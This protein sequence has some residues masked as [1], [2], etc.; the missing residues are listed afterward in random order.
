MNSPVPSVAALPLQS[1]RF[2]DFR[3]TSTGVQCE[4]QTDVESDML[5]QLIATF[6]EP[7]SLPFDGLIACFPFN[8][9]NYLFG[10]IIE[11]SGDADRLLRCH[12]VPNADLQQAISELIDSS[13]VPNVEPTVARLD[14]IEPVLRCATSGQRMILIGTSPSET[15]AAAWEMVPPSC[16]S[17]LTFSA[18]PFAPIGTCIYF[19]DRFDTSRLGHDGLSVIL[20]LSAPCKADLSAFNLGWSVAVHSQLFDS[21]NPRDSLR[22]FYRAHCDTA[23]LSQLESISEQ[24]CVDDEANRRDNHSE[25]E[26]SVESPRASETNLLVFCTD[27]AIKESFGGV[28]DGNVIDKLGQLDDAVFDAIAGSNEGLERMRDLWPTAKSEIAAHLIDES[29]EHY[30]RYVVN[31]WTQRFGEKT[32]PSACLPSME[33]IRIL[34]KDE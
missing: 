29:R 16:W 21:D 8:T 34:F 20:D 9:T 13:V 3:V 27:T 19:S 17:E 12:V 32:D 18:P 28:P 1:Y 33:V 24:W 4:T 5:G 14:K 6:D 26:T 31:E 15:M 23:T 10:F 2:I 30:M 22:S 7:A 11:G 25:R